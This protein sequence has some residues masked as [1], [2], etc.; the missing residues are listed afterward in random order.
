MILP[1]DL[2]INDEDL[3]KSEFI[4]DGDI[5]GDRKA[6]SKLARE[7]TKINSK[8]KKSRV[9]MTKFAELIA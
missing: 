6:Q 7:F 2:K 4:S 8:N 1:Y 5:S 9:I 3:S